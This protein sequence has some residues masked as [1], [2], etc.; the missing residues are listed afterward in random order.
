ML[1]DG[2]AGRWRNATSLVAST[3]HHRALLRKYY[4]RQ[5]CAPSF[6]KSRMLRPL[7]TRFLL[8][9]QIFFILVCIHAGNPRVPPRV[10]PA[11]A[12][13]I[14]IGRLKNYPR[15]KVA[16]FSTANLLFY[17]KTYYSTAKFTFQTNI[18][19]CSRRYILSWRM[20][21]FFSIRLFRPVDYVLLTLAQKELVA[22]PNWGPTNEVHFSVRIRT[23]YFTACSNRK[24]RQ[25]V[26][27]VRPA[28]RKTF[29]I[30]IYYLYSAH[31]KNFSWR[32]T[33][34]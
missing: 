10:N 34:L 4:P 14:Y 8:F 3:R 23:R 24:D 18:C 1:E 29:M 6:V 17:C 5:P 16:Y 21:G 25:P 19:L 30:I 15:Y 31:I 13:I 7:Q 9:Q 28:E 32:F 33:I 11:G 27:T 20:S 12:I 22:V 2:E 26:Y